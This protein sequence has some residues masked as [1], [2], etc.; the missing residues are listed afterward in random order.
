MEKI[1]NIDA[2]IN[3]CLD[4]LLEKGYEINFC[5]DIYLLIRDNGYNI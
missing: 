2:Q 4:G 1:D 5:N 3:T